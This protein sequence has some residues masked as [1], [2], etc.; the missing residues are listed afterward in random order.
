M[1]DIYIHVLYPLPVVLL[2]VLLVPMPEFLRHSYRKAVLTVID[3]VLFRAP[4]SNY[5][6]LTMS[7][8]WTIL[9][10]LAC[11][12]TGIEV[13][14]AHAKKAAEPLGVLSQSRCLRWR[15]ERNL[16]ISILAVTLWVCLHRIRVLMKECEGKTENQQKQTE[17]ARSVCDVSDS[18]KDTKKIA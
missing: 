1:W 12:V 3:S 6:M 16:W 4:F 9:S 18:T 15:S 7:F 10:T 13:L 5:P 14:R 17:R 11:I 2:L 8:V